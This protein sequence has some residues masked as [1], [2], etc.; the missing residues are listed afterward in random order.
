MH[1]KLART[2]LP[3]ALLAVVAALTVAC[4]TSTSGCALS[5]VTVKF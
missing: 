5:S 2:I 1:R 3:L 4:E